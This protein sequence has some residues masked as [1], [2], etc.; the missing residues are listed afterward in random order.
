[1]NPTAMN[2]IYVVFAEALS[3]ERWSLDVFSYSERISVFSQNVL[4]IMKIIRSSKYGKSMTKQQQVDLLA[5]AKKVRE[6]FLH[7]PFCVDP[8]DDVWVPFDDAIVA[9]KEN[10]EDNG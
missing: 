10:D 9:I 6:W 7:A 8:P 3:R 5:A 2:L 1:M 4:T